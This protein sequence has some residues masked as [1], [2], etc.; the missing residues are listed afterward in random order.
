M[1]AGLLR[2]RGELESLFDELARLGTSVEVVM[3]GGAWM[4]WHAQ[5]AST[6]D[7]IRPAASTPTSARPSTAS[8]RA[9]TCSRGGSTTPRAHPLRG[10]AHRTRA[11]SDS[12]E[13]QARC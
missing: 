7:V 6:R 8:A 9:T 3:V 13:S 2:E 11:D 5:R 4:L 12:Y 1:A 10:R